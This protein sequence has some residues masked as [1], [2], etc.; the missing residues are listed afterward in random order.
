MDNTKNQDFKVSAYWQ[1]ELK[2]IWELFHPNEKEIKQSQFEG[3][4]SWR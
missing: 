3:R 2:I 1:D 4:G